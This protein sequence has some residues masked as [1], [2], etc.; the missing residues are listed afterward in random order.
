[1]SLLVCSGSTYVGELLCLRHVDDEVVLVHMLTHHHSGIHLSL[2]EDE[3]L[4]SVLQVVDG[5]SYGR[6]RVHGNHGAVGSSADFPL[7]WLIVLESVCHD[8]FSLACGEHVGSES[9]DSA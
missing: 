2:R 5:I 3:E 1:M 4:A 7:V 8:G 6:T 9:D